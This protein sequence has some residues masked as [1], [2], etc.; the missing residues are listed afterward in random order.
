MVYYNDMHR[1][2]DQPAGVRFDDESP[3]SPILSHVTDMVYF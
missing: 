2:N 1:A 3:K